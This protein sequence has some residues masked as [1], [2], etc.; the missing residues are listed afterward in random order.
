MKLSTTGSCLYLPRRKIIIH[1]IFSCDGQTIVSNTSSPLLLVPISNSYELKH[2]WSLFLHST[3]R[4]K[5]STTVILGHLCKV[6]Q[7]PYVEIMS[8]LYVSYSQHATRFRYLHIRYGSRS[9]RVIGKLWF[10][11]IMTHNHFDEHTNGWTDWILAS[12]LQ[13]KKPPTLNVTYQ[14]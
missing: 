9:L 11:C 14:P 12:K 1:K 7:V 6:T 5:T 10:S 8:V 13:K 3:L 4:H 2:S